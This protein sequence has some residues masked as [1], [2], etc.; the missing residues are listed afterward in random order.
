MVQYNMSTLKTN[1]RDIPEA[2][3]YRFY[4]EKSGRSIVQPFDGRIIKIRSFVNRDTEPSL[5]IYYNEKINRYLWHDHSS[6]KGG[7]AIDFVADYLSKTYSTT[8]DIIMSDYEK[9]IEEGGNLDEYDNA[10]I[11]SE[12]TTFKA[13]PRKFTLNDVDFWRQFKISPNT[14]TKYNVQPLKEYTIF[15]G[16]TNVGRFTNYAF[17]FYSDKHGLY[18][19]YQPETPKMKYLNTKKDYL[20]GSDQLKFESNVCIITS[21]LKDLMALMS[22][23]LNVEAVAPKSENTYIKY[24]A[25]DFLKSKYKHVITMLDNDEPGIKAMKTYQKIYDIPYIHINL[26]QDLAKNNQKNVINFLKLHYTHYIDKIIN[27]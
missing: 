7:T 26:S 19:I 12:T 2:W 6:G 17:G 4:A 27:K 15:K 9:F 18:Q 22:V 25:I 13:C 8:I 5:C 16:D 20:I 14:L 23:E 21:G 1:V 11:E 24:D 10:H 3:I